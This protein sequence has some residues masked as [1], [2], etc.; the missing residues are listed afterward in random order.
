MANFV[1]GRG[2][3]MGVAG[4]LNDNASITSDV[5]AYWPMITVYCMSGM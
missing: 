3:M 1:R 4:S 2:D 5:K